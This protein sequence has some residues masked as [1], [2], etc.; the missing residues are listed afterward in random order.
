MNAKT[1]TA[2][3]RRRQ[4]SIGRTLADLDLR[5]ARAMSAAQDRYETAP[6]DPEEFTSMQPIGSAETLVCYTVDA[7]IVQITGAYIGAEV[8]EPEEFAAHRITAWTLRIQ[9]EVDRDRE[10]AADCGEWAA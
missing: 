5:N 8:V 6:D 2:G 9:A 10:D 4:M 1:P 3:A 7:G